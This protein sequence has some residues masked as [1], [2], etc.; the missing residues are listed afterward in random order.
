M[1]NEQDADPAPGCTGSATDLQFGLDSGG[2]AYIPMT[3]NKV[4]HPFPRGR[5]RRRVSGNTSVRASLTAAGAIVVPNSDYLGTT[6]TTGTGFNPPPLFHVDRSISPY[7]E[8]VLALTGRTD[9]DDSVLRVCRR[10]AVQF[11]CGGSGEHAG[12]LCDHS[13]EPSLCPGA[14][15]PIY[16]VCQGG[17]RDGQPCTGQNGDCPGSATCTAGAMCLPPGATIKSCHVD[18]DCGA[19][20]ECGPGLFDFRYDGRAVDNLVISL[21]GALAR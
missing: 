2:N 17:K 19:G 10:A 9:K 6:T 15:R 5:L 7:P 20:Q 8:N 11:E 21:A 16:Y 4:L 13:T 1:C 3:W 14:C 12:Q 18:A